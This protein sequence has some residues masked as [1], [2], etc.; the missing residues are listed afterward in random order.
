MGLGTN[1]QWDGKCSKGSGETEIWTI[2]CFNVYCTVLKS[3]CLLYSI[4]V[5]MFIIHYQSLN[6]YCS[7]SKSQCLMFILHYQSLNFY[8]SVS[9]S[10]LLL[11]SIK[12]SMFNVYY[13][14][15]IVY[16]Y[17]LKNRKNGHGFATFIKD[18]FYASIIIQSN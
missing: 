17:W 12:V 3:Q 11:F 6:L 15:W 2:Q 5:S 14:V 18:I 1:V 13:T 7:V 10:Q 4:K 8:C 16:V 9:K